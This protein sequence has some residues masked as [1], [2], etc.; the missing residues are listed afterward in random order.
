MTVEEGT[1]RFGEAAMP[2][3]VH[4]PRI[5]DKEEYPDLIEDDARSLK[6]SFIGNL[7][8]GSTYV[9][10]DI[11]VRA[12]ASHPHFNQSVFQFVLI[13]HSSTPISIEWELVAK[14]SKT[15]EPY[16][17]NNPEGGSDRRQTVVFF[18]KAQPTP[19]EGVIELKT[20]TG[21]L[22]GRFIA[23]GFLAGK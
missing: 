22:L 2:T 6:T 11:E 21:K 1:L 4:T 14:M 15:N 18:G 16:T 13:D 19:A 3:K 23:A 20:P 17:A 12:A 8:D 7:W 10:V 9:D 5:D